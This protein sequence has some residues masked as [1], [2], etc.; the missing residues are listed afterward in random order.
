MAATKESR[1]D[2]ADERVD[3]KFWYENKFQIRVLIKTGYMSSCWYAPD[4]NLTFTKKKVSF[5]GFK[6]VFLNHVFGNTVEEK[7]WKAAHYSFIFSSFMVEKLHNFVIQISMNNYM[8]HYT[9]AVYAGL[10]YAS[11]DQPMH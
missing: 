10:G 3:V 9:G 4:L 11:R 7:Y 8:N 5:A 1:D 2:M 6:S